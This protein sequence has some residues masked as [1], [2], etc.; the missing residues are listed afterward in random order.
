MSLEEVD[1]PERSSG[2][3]ALV[4]A[5]ILA[6]AQLGFAVGGLRFGLGTTRR[7]LRHEVRLLAEARSLSQAPDGDGRRLSVVVDE[8][9]G[10]IREIGELAQEEAGRLKSQLIELDAEVRALIAEGSGS[11]G[12]RRHGKPTE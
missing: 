6:R 2:E 3:A 5:L 12:H 7:I 1:A 9:R 4:L 11:A 10:C 8:V